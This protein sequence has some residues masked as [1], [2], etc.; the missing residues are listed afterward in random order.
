MKHSALGIHVFAGGFTLGVK[1][2]MGV[3]DHLE[4]HN[5]GF[6]TAQKI[7][8]AEVHRSPF[9]GWP[10]PAKFSHCSTAFG[11]PR[12]TAFSSVTGGCD[13]TSHGWTG[14]QTRD[15]VELCK[16]AAGHFDFI[17]WESVQQAYSTGRPLLD[18]MYEELFRPRGYRLA[19]VFV[20]AAS[21]GNVQNRR[22]Y[23]F[24][25]YADKYKFNVQPPP[26]PAHKQVLWDAIGE[27]VDYETVPQDGYRGSLTP[28]TSMH[29]FPIEL[30]TAPRMP[31]DWCLNAMGRW[32]CHLLPPVLQSKWRHR[33][34]EMPFSLHCMRRISMHKHSPTIFSGS[35][36]FL[37]P[38][39]DRGMTVR[40]F[41]AIMGWPR[42]V[43]PIGHDAVP[44]LAK[45]IVPAVG[46]WLAEQVVLSAS[47][48][49]GDD[50]WY[51]RYDDRTKQWV[52]G[53]AS[54][55]EQKVLDLTEWYAKEQCWSRF[56][57][58][59]MRPRYPVPAGIEFTRALDNRYADDG[60]CL[61]AA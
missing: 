60:Y 40:E 51:T 27:F 21:F 20:N 39:Y 38:W 4:V 37:H 36:R 47:G 25:A 28:D 19:H 54:C 15:A 14:K 48:H 5:L 35:R 53:D 8:G 24:V 23:F 7:V 33:I 2:V 55:M 50:D 13:R 3:T 32:A 10:S 34:S 49:W 45:G 9:E 11:N 6:D 17:I 56:P 46:K 42:D 43:F 30:E 26:I 59:A 41:A 44:Q 31:T 12:C 29:M 58:G 57:P 1:E 61:E 52:G 16:Y 18:W 22:R